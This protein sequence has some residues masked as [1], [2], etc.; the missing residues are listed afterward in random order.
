[1]SALCILDTSI[2]CELLQIPRKSQ[3]TAGFTEEFKEKVEDRHEFLLPLAVIFETGNHIG[4]SKGDRHRLAGKLRDLVQQSLA[5]KA[6]FTITP[7]P[8]REELHA[9]LDGFPTWARGGSGLADFSIQ[10]T[11]ND[12]HR[13]MP[14]R[15]VYI[16]SRDQH[17]EGYDSGA[18]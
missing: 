5:G 18:T 6:P 7:L 17:L 3:P 10:Q 16:W 9:L 2:L 1:L 13:Q 12:L 15:R 11:W 4:H 8:Q 14:N